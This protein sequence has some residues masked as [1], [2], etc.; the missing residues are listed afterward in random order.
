MPISSEIPKQYFQ[1]KIILRVYFLK[2]L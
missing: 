2:T 1:V